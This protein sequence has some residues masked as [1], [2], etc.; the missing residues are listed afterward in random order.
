MTGGEQID[1]LKVDV[2]RSELEIFG[3]T[4][5][6]W[7]P[8]VRNICIELHG[9]DCREVFLRALKDF[10]YDLGVSGELTL[11]RNLDH[12]R[13]S[14]EPAPDLGQQGALSHS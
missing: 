13:T 11:C 10:E 12:K 3:D 9:A 7:L 14:A 1:I 2:E 8:R 4:S 5:S 6:S